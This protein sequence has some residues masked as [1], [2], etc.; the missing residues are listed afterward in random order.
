MD[1][2]YDWFLGC[3]VLEEGIYFERNT[4]ALIKKVEFFIIV[5]R[6]ILGGCVKKSSLLYQY[7]WN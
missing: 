5:L 4:G 3:L 7:F 6:S 2:I 1:M